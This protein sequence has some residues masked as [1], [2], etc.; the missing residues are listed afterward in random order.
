MNNHSPQHPPFDGIHFVV[1]E[2]NAFAFVQQLQN[3]HQVGVGVFD[4]IL[5]RRLWR[6]SPHKRVLAHPFQFR[7]H[8]FGRQH[9][10]DHPLGNG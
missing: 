8:F 10:I 5:G 9:K 1:T 6:I 7:C 2:I 4:G 3:N